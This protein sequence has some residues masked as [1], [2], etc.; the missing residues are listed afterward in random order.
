M[1]GKVLCVS[2][3]LF[4]AVSSGLA[5]EAHGHEHSNHD[6]YHKEFKQVERWVQKF[7]G[8]KRDEW[9]LPE[10]VI[11]KL[12]IQDGCSIADIGAGTGYFSFRI[13]NLYPGAKVYAVDVEP[14]MVHY[15]RKECKKRHLEN[16]I[17]IQS[18]ATDAKLPEPVDLILVVD[19]YHHIDNRITYFENL[20]SKMKSGG[21]I[22][23]IDFNERSKE[24]PPL[25]YRIQKADLIGELREAG[26]EL[27][28]DLQFL[29]NQ[30]FVEFCSSS[31]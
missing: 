16:V 18:S 10:S 19:T 2:L 25:K 29:P 1:I 11:A 31:Q 27:K 12:S 14:E 8:P 20:K 24:G 15:L 5:I 21:R 6:G 13:G 23:I 17:P 9:Q 30:Y 4:A 26:F 7:D 3:V 28:R 22:V